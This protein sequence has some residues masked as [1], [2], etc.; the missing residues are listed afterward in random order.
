MTLSAQEAGTRR[1]PW[2]LRLQTA[3]PPQYV[4][5]MAV[6]ERLLN[7]AHT[8]SARVLTTGLMNRIWPSRALK[9]GCMPMFSD[10]LSFGG[11][12]QTQPSIMLSLW[13]YDRR[14]NTPYLASKRAQELTYGQDHFLVSCLMMYMPTASMT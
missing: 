13:P 3:P 7:F 11:V 5:L 2:I 9:D 12:T 10:I 14:K 4:E 8:G 6:L 1:H